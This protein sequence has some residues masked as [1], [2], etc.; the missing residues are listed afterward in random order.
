M[1]MADKV[2]SCRYELINRTEQRANLTNANSGQECRPAPVFLN[3]FTFLTSFPFI[4]PVVNKPRF[5]ALFGTLL[6]FHNCTSQVSYCFKQSNAILHFGDAAFVN[7]K[8]YILCIFAIRVCVF[9]F[10]VFLY[11]CFF[12]DLR[13][14]YQWATSR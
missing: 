4:V 6:K 12:V 2:A 1:T 13:E 5:S 10:Y 14:N 3:I 7:Q 9:V 8:L 11:L